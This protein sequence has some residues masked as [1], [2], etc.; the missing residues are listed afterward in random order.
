MEQDNNRQHA[1]TLVRKIVD[2]RER[3]V[4]AWQQGADSGELTQ[5]R[6]NIQHLDD[7]LW[8]AS[9]SSNGVAATRGT[10][11]RRI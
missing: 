3:F 4:S 6:Q 10:G 5:I 11:G 8:N 2:E 1:E 9:P 7:L